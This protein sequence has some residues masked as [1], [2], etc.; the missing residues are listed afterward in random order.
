MT[1]EYN[2]TIQL[3]HA[4]V[5]VIHKKSV[6]PWVEYLTRSRTSTGKL[7]SP[8]SIILVGAILLLVS[9][10]KRN[11]TLNNTIVNILS[12]IINKTHQV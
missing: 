10:V 11:T 2:Q 8:C 3:H 9:I 4:I 5:S 1:T 6:K 7:L 12:N